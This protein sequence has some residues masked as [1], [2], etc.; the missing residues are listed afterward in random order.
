VLSEEDRRSWREELSEE[1]QKL[2]AR[3]LRQLK[4]QGKGENAI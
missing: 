4:G 2:R 3:L 1:Q